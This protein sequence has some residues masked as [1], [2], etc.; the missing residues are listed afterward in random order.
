[1]SE[2]KII[3]QNAD[4]NVLVLGDELSR[5]TET[6]SGTALTIATIEHLTKNNSSYIFSTHMH[7]L[8]DTKQIST[9]ADKIISTDTQ[10][11][12]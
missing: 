7:H 6:G 1:M 4:Q 2:L 8:V 9:L 12:I 11:I 10:A 3:L 5:G